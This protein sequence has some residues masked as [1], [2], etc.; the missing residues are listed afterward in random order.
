M[1]T[2]IL[3]TH[4]VYDFLM[5]KIQKANNLKRWFGIKKAKEN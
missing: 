2:A 1:L 5:S 4:G 3:G